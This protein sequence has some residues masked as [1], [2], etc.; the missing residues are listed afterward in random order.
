MIQLP[1]LATAE[2]VLRREDRD[3]RGVVAA[4]LHEAPLAPAPLQ[5]PREVEAAHL[6]RAPVLAIRVPGAR[7]HAGVNIARK[8]G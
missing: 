4:L 1:E 5:R 6:P 8:K 7:P 2:V 3:P